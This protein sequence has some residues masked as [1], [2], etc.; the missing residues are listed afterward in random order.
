MD[1]VVA[2]TDAPG[3][4][5]AMS[6]VV[7]TLDVAATLGAL[8]D[9]VVAER[10]PGGFEL[11]IV[12]N[13][14]SDGTRAL[15]RSYADRADV[16]VLDASDRRGPGAA[17]NL[18][19]Q[20]AR[21]EGIVFLDGDDVISPGYLAAMQRALEEYDLVGSATDPR[22]MGSDEVAPGGV[23]ILQ[24]V[25]GL[26]TGFLPWSSSSN[27][28]V[29]RTV[30]LAVGGFDEGMRY[31]SEDQDLCWRVQTDGGTI[32]FVPDAIL[33]CNLPASRWEGVRKGYPRGRGE[34]MMARKWPGQVT[35]QPRSSTLRQLAGTAW[36]CARA[37]DPHD[38]GRW[39]LLF[40]RNLGRLFSRA[41][42]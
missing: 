15:A 31:G 32:G 22:P 9:G 18:G 34:H 37:S 14:S 16:R 4:S 17:R 12:D 27:L 8:L 21:G 38:R 26:R 10:V 13:G 40:G 41:G 1:E 3:R 39:G 33:R 24:G 42:R 20:D 7:P 35:S 19:V 11:V 6:V 28:G 25:D 30:F 29:R 23:P 36:R 2:V 5:P